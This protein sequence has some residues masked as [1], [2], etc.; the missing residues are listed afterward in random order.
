MKRKTSK[1][2][3]G[4]YEKK[5]IT[6]R[7][8]K[9][10]VAEAY[11]SVRT[12]IEFSS[13]D[14]SVK[15][16][17]VTSAMQEEGKTVVA[18]NIAV[19]MALSGK[20]TLM[21]DADLRNPTQHK[22][23]NIS[24]GLG[25]TNILINENLQ[26]EEVAITVPTNNLYIIPSGPLPPNPAE[27]VNSNKMRSFIA[28][29]NYFDTII[30]DSPPVTVVTDAAIMASY[31]DGVVLIV[32]SGQ[33]RKEQASAACDQLRRVKANIL[34]VVLNKVPANGSYFYNYYYGS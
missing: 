13:F 15:T 10:V 17:L 33:V 16:I 7:N 30:V 2:T 20:K 24:N 26:L 5:L 22:I 3:I 31:L 18:A 21:I 4:T 29:L 32:A 23:F 9:S 6:F 14:K 1:T 27:L 12:N 11:R 34:G 25:L 8:P 19:A 28:S